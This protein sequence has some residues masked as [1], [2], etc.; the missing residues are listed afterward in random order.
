MPVLPILIY[1]NPS[2]KKVSDAVD[3]ND[4]SLQSLIQDLFETLDASPNCTGVAAPQV[5]VLKRVIAIDA[6][7]NAKAG[8]NHGRMALINPVIHWQSG[9][10][11]AREGCLSIPDFTANIK[12]ATHIKF[13]AVLSDGR[14]IDEETKD[15]EARLILHEVDH[16][17]GIL[18]L[19]RVASLKTDVFRRKRLQNT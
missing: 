10:A 1:P 17:D 6:S 14:T 7:R 15:F 16:L 12:R 19:D 2:L 8:P 13:T 9:E 5:G 18:F 4:S 3:L 11:I